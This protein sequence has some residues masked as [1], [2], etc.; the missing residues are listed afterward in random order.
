MIFLTTRWEENRNEWG[1]CER[2]LKLHAFRKGLLGI[3]QAKTG[4]R[5]SY[6]P[7]L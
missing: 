5:K 1:V 7:D 4:I 2:A 6:L 3:S